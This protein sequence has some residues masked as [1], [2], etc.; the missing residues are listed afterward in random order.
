[1][2]RYWLRCAAVLA[3]A[4]AAVAFTSSTASAAW[5]AGGMGAAASGALTMPAGSTPSATG[6][7]DSITVTWAA[8]SLADGTAVSG[9]VIERFNSSTGAP[10][11]VG[12]GCS[13][14]VTGTSC[15]E[16]NVPAGSWT[17]TDTPVIQ[18]WTGAASA[19]S[20]PVTLG[21]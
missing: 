17:Y 16:L 19:P 12:A 2:T 9:Y 18:L 11:T 7:R 5:S 4:A 8:A 21:T 20:A 1:M 15:T 13:G 10:A 6:L 3:L 14:T